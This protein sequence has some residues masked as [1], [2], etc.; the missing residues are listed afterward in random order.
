MDV[1]H[2]FDRYSRLSVRRVKPLSPL[3]V[4][5]LA[6]LTKSTLPVGSRTHQHY[7]QVSHSSVDYY[8]GG[9]TIDISN[10]GICRKSAPTMW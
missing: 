5:H 3:L 6:P 9:L 8:E 7:L 1:S 4:R 2:E 10:K